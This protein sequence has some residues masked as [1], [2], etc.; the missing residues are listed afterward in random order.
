MSQGLR[1]AG[2]TLGAPLGVS[3]LSTRTEFAGD[4][5]RRQDA[6]PSTL[7]AQLRSAS[8]GDIQ[9]FE[10]LYDRM[11][12]RIY[13]LALRVLTDAHQAEEVTQEIFLQIWQTASRFDPQRGSALAWL[14]TIAHRRAVDRVRRSEG[15]R[16]LDAQD[17]ERS[18]RTPYDTTGATAHAALDAQEVRAA[19]AVL[20]PIQR[21]SLELAYFG[22]YTYRE[23]SA[24]LQIPVS[25]AKT[26]VRD[27][28]IRLRATMSP[29]AAEPARPGS[30]SATR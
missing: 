13:G 17:A 8:R 22:G 28:L 16:R 27:A 24:L 29:V 25:T 20:S 9:A 26:R 12:P 23:V 5:R 19:L 11:A 15:W 10:N 30:H 7:E 1:G 3:L 6:Q 21:Q 18:R 4:L 14:M 2:G